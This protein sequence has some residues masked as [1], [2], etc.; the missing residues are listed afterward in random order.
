MYVDEAQRYIHCWSKLI[1]ADTVQPLDEHEI[2]RNNHGGQVNE[3]HALPE[4]PG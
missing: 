3:I 2:T 4:V 1:V